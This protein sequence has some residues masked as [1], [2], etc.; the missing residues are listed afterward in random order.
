MSPEWGTLPV[1]V[2]ARLVLLTDGAFRRH[3]KK[4]ALVVAGD[5]SGIDVIAAL[6]SPALTRVPALLSL[7][8]GA[9]MPLARAGKG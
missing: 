2:V 6:Q 9:S 4:Q 3:V 7:P 1:S 8:V 5:I